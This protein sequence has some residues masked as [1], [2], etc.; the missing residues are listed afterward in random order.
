MSAL[1]DIDKIDDIMEMANTMA[2]LKIPS[3]GLKTLDQMKAKVKETLQSSKK[4]SSWTAKEAFSVLTEAKKEDERKRATLLGFYERT[5]DCLQSMDGKV[6]NLLEQNIGNLKEKI[7]SHKQNLLKKEYIVLVAGE[8]SSGKSTLLNLI[9]GE[10][11]LPYSVLS[12]TSTICE[13]RY[14]DIPKLVVHFKNKELGDTTKTVVLDEPSEASEQSYLQQISKF[15][16]LKTDREKGSDYE[17]IELFWPHN[18]LKENIVIVD[19]P[20]IGESTIMDDIVKEYLPEAFAFI[21]VINSENA[22]GIQRD[23]VEKLIEHARQISLDKQRESSSNCALFVCNKWDQVPS[24][25]SDEVKN[26]VVTKLTQCWPSLDPESQIIYMSA[27]EA[28]EA[29]KLGVVTEEFAELM[30]GIKSMVLKSIEARLQIQWRWLDYLLAR[31]ALHTKAFIR[32]SSEDRKNVIDRM[33]FITDRLQS[34]ERQ[35]GTVSKELQ[36]YLENKTDHAV[37]TLSRYLKSSEVIEQFSLWTLDDVPNTEESWELTKNYIQKALMRRL[38]EK[39]EEWEEK[40]HIFSDAR[41]S[42]IQY[43]QERFSYVEG[44]LRM[45]EGSVLAGDAVGSG[46]DPLA[47]DD[48]SV[49]EKVIIGVTS[50]IWVPVGLVVLVVSVPVVGAIAVKEKLENW[51]KIRQYNKDKCAFMAKASQEYLNEAAEEQHLKSYVMEQLKEAEVCL[52]QVLERIP[53]LIEEDKMLCQQLRDEN[54]SKKEVEDFYQPLHE[55][56]VKIRDEMA[57]FGIK[58][59]RTMDISCDDL[60]W[61]DYAPL[62]KGA[63]AAVYRGKLKMRGKDKPVDVAVKVWNEELNEDTASDILSES[64]ILR[65]LNYPFIVKFYGTALHKEGE[66]LKAI[67]V[68]ELCKENLRHIF[69]HEDNIPGKS[70]TATAT[71]DVIGWAKD[72]ANALEYI[73]RQGIVH[74]DLKLEN[75]LLSQENIVKVADVGVSKEAKAI[76]GTMVGTPLYL[77][78][79]VIKSR[80]YDYKADIYSFGIMLWEMWYGIRALL[81]VGGNVHE[82][83]EKVGEGVRPKHVRGS[84]KPPPCWH[85]L[86]QRCWDEKPDNRPDASECYEKLAELYQEFGA[87]SS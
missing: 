87:P 45:L 9:L 1:L 76:T 72:I 58:E 4:K 78:P 32:N 53:Q 8:T 55:R 17:K 18:L 52:K 34:I 81:D 80:L 41:A 51:N 3:K 69:R 74:R 50:P 29:Q 46:S 25:E 33:K 31:M 38:Q 10:Q 67:L 83:F 57:L 84:K 71:R 73:H 40:N 43:F 82:F 20:G 59:V 75:I 15:V 85:E 14:G 63:F 11:L 36:S 37:S 19:S 77:A 56:S 6:H 47:S 35:Q 44:Q 12:T 70:S 49:A 26:Y 5:D 79:E 39:I 54:R 61:Q 27:K 2:T 22:G 28:S 13:L 23:R 62:G 42:L 66:R 65:K 7:A 60:E 48:F 30:N 68:M 16:H 64:E 86:M 21:Y 24:K